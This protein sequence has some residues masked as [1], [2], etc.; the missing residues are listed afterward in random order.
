M[1]VKKVR[2][3]KSRRGDKTGKERREEEIRGE[4]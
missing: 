3:Q 2:P 4:G 1:V